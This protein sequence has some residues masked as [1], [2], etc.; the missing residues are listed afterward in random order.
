M[1][2]ALKRIS[3]LTVAT[4]VS[5]AALASGATELGG[6]NPP[7]VTVRAWDLDLKEPGEV[8][9]LYDR[10]HDAASRMCRD[11]AQR[12]WRTTR[13]RVDAGWEE[14]CV[15]DAVDT[16]VRDFGDP[17]LAAMHIRTGVALRN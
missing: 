2:N 16:A 7:T 4:T 8:Q 17:L 12:H 1:T 15:T 6:D 11:E 10:V 5:F 9:T 3:V 13:R 14:A